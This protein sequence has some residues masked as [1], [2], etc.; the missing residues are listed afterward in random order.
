MNH[1]TLT[2]EL[3]TKQCTAVQCCLMYR[4]PRT[5]VIVVLVGA[6]QVTACATS[7][8]RTPT[9]DAGLRSLIAAE[10][11]FAR[12]SERSGIKESFLANL[13]ADGIL[14]RPGPV[15][16]IEWLS[17]RP[18]APGYLSWDPEV[19]EIS[20]S[21]EMGWTTGPWELRAKD[22]SD[23]VRAAGHYVTVWRRDSTGAWKMAV[24]IGTGHRFM[25]KPADAA[26]RVLSAKALGTDPLRLLVTRDS[27]LGVGGPSQ[28][29]KLI[30]AMADDARLHREGA[31]P[32][33]G[34]SA[35]RQALSGDDRPYRSRYLGG[36]VSRAAD[37]GY[38][39][40]EYEL[41]PTFNGPAERGFYLRL[42]RPG[43]DG[44]WRIALDLAQPARPPG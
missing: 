9:G 2:L 33:L 5:L 6:A 34:M 14:F 32:A 25:P 41:L 27:A 10:R 24:D 29:A 20:A 11:G 28:S 37:F 13:G 31:V 4:L 15:N 12:H 40:G 8:G 3:S 17:K 43:E 23:T 35:V 18:P 39:Y 19:A 7:G 1:R 22:R 30:P 38:S 26:G 21:G 42:W 16:G 36:G 44:S